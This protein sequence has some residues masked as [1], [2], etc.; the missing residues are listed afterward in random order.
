MIRKVKKSDRGDLIE[1]FKE[2]YGSDA[3]VKDIPGEYHERAFDEM[4]RSD[5]YLEGLIFTEEQ[6]AVGYALLAKTY[7]HEA[8]GMTVWIEELYVRSGYRNRGIGEEF[9]LYLEKNYPASRYRLEIEPANAGAKRLYERKGYKT[10][11]YV[12]MSKENF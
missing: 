3:V 12:E 6:K 2:F 10:L 8:G 9:F 1:M 5:E 4:M 7:S 11:A